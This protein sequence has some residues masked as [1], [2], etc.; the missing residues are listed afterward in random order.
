IYEGE[1]ALFGG[2]PA[3]A[4]PQRRAGFAVPH[5][6]RGLGGLWYALQEAARAPGGEQRREPFPVHIGECDEGLVMVERQPQTRERQFGVQQR[7]SL[8]PR[9]PRYGLLRLAEQIPDRPRHR[10]G[11]AALSPSPLRERVQVRVRGGV[12]G[13]V[14]AAPHAGDRGEQDECVQAVVVEQIV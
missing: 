9:S 7:K 14:S 6:G 1:L 5:V 13:M 11:A 2:Q 12:T 8:S 4:L 10:G 3:K